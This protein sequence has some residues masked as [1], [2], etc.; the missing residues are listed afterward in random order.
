MLIARIGMRRDA[1]S[2]GAAKFPPNQV[3]FITF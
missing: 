1:R 2:F 3:R